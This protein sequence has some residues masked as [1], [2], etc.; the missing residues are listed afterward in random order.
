[1]MLNVRIDH[2]VYWGWGMGKLYAYRYTVTTRMMSAGEGQSHK[3][4]STDNN[5]TFF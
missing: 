4:V 5:W 1:M 2:K 3:T